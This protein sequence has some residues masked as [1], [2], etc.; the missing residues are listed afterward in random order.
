MIFEEH[1]Q[2]WA[3]LNGK[4][5][6]PMSFGEYLKLG[7]PYERQSRIVARTILSHR[8][9]IVV[10]TVF[11]G[12]DHSYGGRPKWFETMIFGT[13]LNDYQRRY[14][15][16]E[17]A[18]AGHREAVKRAK[19]ARW[20]RGEPFHMRRCRRDLARGMRAMERYQ[21]KGIVFKYTPLEET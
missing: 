2:R 18:E 14:E 6:V 8:K 20:V 9:R 1:S 5:V 15:L 11:L 16:W 12:L 21:G 17:E 3:I 7:A 10:S 13:S 4:E 19:Q